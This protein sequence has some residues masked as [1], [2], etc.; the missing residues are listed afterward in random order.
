MQVG[1]PPIRNAPL[2]RVTLTGGQCRQAMGSPPESGRSASGVHELLARRPHQSTL[3]MDE[4]LLQP[5]MMTTHSQ[6]FAA[7][8]NVD[9]PPTLSLIK[10]RRPIVDIRV[11]WMESRTKALSSRFLEIVVLLQTPSRLVVGRA[12]AS[13]RGL[14]A[15]F[16][17]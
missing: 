15:L 2:S 16:T 4:R 11:A 13:V 7:T 17:L 5:R 9:M 1:T 10:Q 3:G 12:A 6:S 14:A 8:T